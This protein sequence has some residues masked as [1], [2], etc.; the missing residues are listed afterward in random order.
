MI[1]AWSG[2]GDDFD[3]GLDRPLEII[4]YGAAAFYHETGL[5]G[6]SGPTDFFVTDY[7]GPLPESEAREWTQL[8]LWANPDAYLGDLMYL[9][10]DPAA[11]LTP[12]S[13]RT[14]MLELVAVPEGVPDAPPV[15]TQWNIPSTD[16][17]MLELPTYTTYDGL[18]SYE[19]T[20]SVGP[21]ECLAD[22]GGSGGEPDGVTDL[23]DLALLL[24]SYGL[25]TDNP[26]F[27]SAADLTGGPEGEP[28]GC[29]S[30]ADLALL[31]ADY[32]CGL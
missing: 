12:P 24:S 31:L 28:D 25:C 4:G 1:S 6:W 29:V 18:D 26:G 20:F 23:T 5:A 22:I 11:D 27:V 21:V 9:S 7:R 17:F 16:G 19:F 14:Y 2:A 30:L 10:L 15:G 3:A 8:Y 32:G 13:N